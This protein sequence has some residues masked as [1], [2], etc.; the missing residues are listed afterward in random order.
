MTKEEFELLETQFQ[1]DVKLSEEMI[2]K[3]II[4]LPMIQSKYINAYHKILNALN[5][6]SS[7]KDQLFHLFM[8]EYRSGK[9]DL[10]SFTWGATELKKMIETSPRFIELT[11]KEMQY[12]SQLKTVEEM[13]NIVKG[14]GYSINNYI[15]YKKLIYGN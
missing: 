10:S 4:S 6:I 8:M 7:Q 12:E 13:I 1:E 15:T 3:Q 9:S 5:D 14:M 2:E 11:K